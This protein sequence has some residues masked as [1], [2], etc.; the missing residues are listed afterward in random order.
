ML[1]PENSKNEAEDLLFI[2][3]TETGAVGYRLTGFLAPDPVICAR[4]AG[5]TYLAASSLEYGRA[6]K[7]ATA[8]HVLSF[9]ELEVNRLAREMKDGSRALAAAV[10]GLLAEKG[11]DAVVVPPTFGV[12]YA[13]ELRSRGVTVT[14]AQSVFDALRRVKSD[15]EVSYIEETQR[16][17]EDSCYRAVTVLRESEV[18]EDG[19]LVW[20][21]ATL[22]SE[23]LRAEIEA[24]LLQA[25]CTT[26]GTITAGG[27]QAADPHEVGHG[28]LRAGETIILDIFPVNKRTRYYADMT[29]TFVKGE[30]K[31]PELTRMYETVLA[32][33]EAALAMI[34][35]GV[36]GRDVHLKVSEILHE[37]GYE[38]AHHDQKPGSPLET[39]F[40]H[41][42]GHGLGLEIHE[43]P[44]VSLANEEL[45]P[46]DVVT[47]E[48]GVYYPEY[49][50]VRIEDLVVVTED[51][52]RNLT[53]FPK[54]GTDFVIE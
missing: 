41:S 22:T 39:G 54:S 52:C 26:R 34:R 5:E 35:A 10:A 49:G 48:P 42:T 20:G 36:N 38:T 46:G 33:Q 15:E 25:D 21:G 7:Q 3:D 37:A 4:I 6:K 51:G 44:R 12:A 27:A 14:P 9:E 43:S 13:D 45:L 47:I 31:D 53:R 2:G 8:D 30:P 16:A 40:I 23:L 1:A 18:A 29:R 11:S 17:V 50:G 24:V 19:T 32:S 28:P